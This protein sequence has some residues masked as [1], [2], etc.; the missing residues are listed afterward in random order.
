MD[1][2]DFN[3]YNPGFDNTLATGSTYNLQL[4]DDKMKEFYTK[5]Y[6]ILN[7]SVDQLLKSVNSN[8]KNKNDQKYP[9]DKKK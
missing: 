7:Q 9:V 5:K 1:I 4:P 6:E 3:R 8:F 2:S